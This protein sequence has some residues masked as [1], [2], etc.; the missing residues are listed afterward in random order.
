[1]Y[2]AYW[3]SG[4]GHSSAWLDAGWQTEE[5][6]PGGG[7]VTFR[8]VGLPTAQAMGSAKAGPR[9]L[10]SSGLPPEPSPSPGPRSPGLAWIDR[11]LGELVKRRPVFHSE[12]D[13][14]HALAWALHEEGAERIRL[15]RHY[16]AIGGYLDLEAELKGRRLAIELKYW[17][18]AQLVEIE[19][20][21]FNLKNQAAHPLSRYDF[22]KDITRLERLV[23]NGDADVGY[24]ITLTNDPS[25]WRESGR[26][27]ID[28]DFRL[29]EGRELQGRLAW[30]ERAGA[31]TTRSREIPLDLSGSYCAH[32]RDYAAVGDATLRYL[33]LKIL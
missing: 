18:R 9:G 7:R 2:S 26:D 24:A 17:T 3:S 4:Q 23:A 15:E 19:D 22:L 1:M 28:L 8:R 13:F 27:A 5:V 21:K 33:A 25:Y 16:D 20:E 31:G 32:W 14:Q 10:V 29:H 6:D 30:A 12:A 11:L